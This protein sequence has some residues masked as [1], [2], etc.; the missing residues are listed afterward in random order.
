MRRSRIASLQ[1]DSRRNGVI[2]SVSTRNRNV[3]V[4]VSSVRGRMGVAPRVSGRSPQRGSG[5][6]Q[7]PAR[8]PQWLEDPPSP[9]GGALPHQ[10]LPPSPLRD[11][12][13]G[14]PEAPSSVVLPQ[15]HTG[16]YRRDLVSV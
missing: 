1:R 14:G 3:H 5:G 10:A 15:V 8:N 16:I 11:F 4:P 2:A 12:V 13:G 6:G 7:K 9:V